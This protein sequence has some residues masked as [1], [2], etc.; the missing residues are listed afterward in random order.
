MHWGEW[1]QELKCIADL[2]WL[3]FD[4]VT[5]WVFCQTNTLWFINK[6]FKLTL[7]QTCHVCCCDCPLGPPLSTS[8]WCE[9]RHGECNEWALSVHIARH[10]TDGTKKRQ[11]EWLKEE[12][13]TADASRS[14]VVDAVMHAHHSPRFSQSVLAH[15]ACTPQHCHVRYS[16][17]LML[18]LEASVPT[19]KHSS[20]GNVRYF[21][22]AHN[23]ITFSTTIL[24]LM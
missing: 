10:A 20:R 9:W 22:W 15:V 19:D 8:V 6:P 4:S 11:T 24:A 12:C 5:M 2:S 13:T 14:E 17:K 21:R 7:S 1:R 23:I 18:P 16:L 3:V